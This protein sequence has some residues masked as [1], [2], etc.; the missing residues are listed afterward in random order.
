[1]QTRLVWCASDSG[2]ATADERCDVALRPR[3]QRACDTEPCTNTSWIVS[4]WSGVRQSVA[5]SVS[6]R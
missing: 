2:D 6:V 1:V 3:H 5:M 4:G